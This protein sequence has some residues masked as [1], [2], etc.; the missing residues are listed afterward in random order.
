MPKQFSY[1]ILRGDQ[2]I[3][4]GSNS[5]RH[6]PD[7]KPFYDALYA[8]QKTAERVSIVLFKTKEPADV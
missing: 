6:I 2:V 5:D 7:R 4:T 3:A 8:A 1:S